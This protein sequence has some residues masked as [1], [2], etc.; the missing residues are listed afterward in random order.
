MKQMYNQTEKPIYI[1]R[2]RESL[3]EIIFFTICYVKLRFN[4][5][6]FAPT[7]EF[8]IYLNAVSEW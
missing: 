4:L 8:F 7:E 5:R 1:Y 3:D 6:L 2:E